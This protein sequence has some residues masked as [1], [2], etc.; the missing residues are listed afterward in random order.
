MNRSTVVKQFSD[1]VTHDDIIEEE[2]DSLETVK[3]VH[4]LQEVGKNVYGLP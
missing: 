1:P 3:Y 2:E 4:L